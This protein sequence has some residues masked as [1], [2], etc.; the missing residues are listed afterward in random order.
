M[1]PKTKIPLE[2]IWP[3]LRDTI[4]VS[5]QKSEYVVEFWGWIHNYLSIPK[6][7][8]CNRLSLGMDK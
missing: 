1:F 2:T 3:F 4:Y 7:Q 6:F 5:L 8:Q